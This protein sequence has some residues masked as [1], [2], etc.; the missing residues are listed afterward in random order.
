LSVAGTFHTLASSRWK[1]T[2]CACHITE[3]LTLARVATHRIIQSIDVGLDELLEQDLD[4]IFQNVPTSFTITI[5][6]MHGPLKPMTSMTT[7]TSPVHGLGTAR[8][9]EYAH[10]RRGGPQNSKSRQQQR[11]W[12]GDTC[13]WVCRGSHQ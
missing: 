3:L 1:P 9:V 10:R 12:R 5:L 6:A 11:D 7:S 2:A 8:A 4:I 13:H